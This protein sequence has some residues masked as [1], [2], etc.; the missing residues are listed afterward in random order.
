MIKGIKICGV[1]D[2]KT[3]NYIIEHPYP[4]QFIGFVTNYKKSKRYVEFEKLKELINIDKKGINFVSVLVN[5]DDEILEMIKNL[6]F[7]YYQL[8]D[9][10]PETTKLIKE[11]Y[12]IK[13][14]SALTINNKDD[15]N[16]YKKYETISDIILFDGKGYEK[17]IGFN[18]KFIESVPN[19][20]SKMIAGNIKIEDISNFKN[21][22]NYILDLSGAL[23]KEKGVKDIN[24]IDKLL[25]SVHNN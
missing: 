16:Q 17:S 12:K 23:E 14:I 7:D 15:V 10:N 2:L 8:Y 11:K 18:H 20:I 3:L 13:I 25:N 24:K 9:V 19:K 5:P 1:T 4:P 21:T 6:K 22:K